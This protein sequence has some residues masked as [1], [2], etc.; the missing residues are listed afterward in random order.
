MDQK[1]QLREK[2]VELHDELAKAE[3]LDDST[4]AVLKD[5]HSDIGQVLDQ[6]EEQEHMQY[7]PLMVR[8]RANV[9]HLE[10]T[11]PRVTSAIERAIDALVQMGV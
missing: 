11:H 4:I 2:L 3:S 1:S 9:T 8:L 5:L 6:P 7:A 10:T